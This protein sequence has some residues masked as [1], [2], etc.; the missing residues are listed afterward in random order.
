[1]EAFIEAMATLLL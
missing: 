1:M